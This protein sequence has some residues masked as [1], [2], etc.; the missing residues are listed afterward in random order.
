MLSK[1]NNYLLSFNLFKVFHRGCTYHML[2]IY[3]DY[4][5]CS[6]GYPS[7]ISS[8]CHLMKS[9]EL[10]RSQLLWMLAIFSWTEH[11]SWMC[12]HISWNKLCPSICQCNIWRRLM[13][14]SH[15]QKSPSVPEV[16]SIFGLNELISHN[17]IYCRSVVKTH[18]RPSE[19]FL[20]Q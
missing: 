17:I 19:F 4:Q 18:G 7:N 11:Q 6:T 10:Q 3:N 9:N 8:S 2:N 14:T 1:W 15:A 12:L 13:H 16:C 5:F 20:P